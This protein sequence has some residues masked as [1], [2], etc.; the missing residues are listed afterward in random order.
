MTQ[1]QDL[2]ALMLTVSR[3]MLDQAKSGN[4][5]TV[6][7]LEENRQ[8]LIAEIFKESTDRINPESKFGKNIQE[9]IQI[10]AQI[11]SLANADKSKVQDELIEINKVRNQ[12]KAYQ[13]K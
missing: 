12:A 13:G 4:W 8:K 6:T 9:I 7:E 5:Q 2:K 1:E 3:K 11:E 10:D